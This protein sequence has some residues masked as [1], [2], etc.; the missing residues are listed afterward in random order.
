VDWFKHKTGSLD[1]PDLADAVDKHGDAA[2]LFFFGVLEI[3]GREF[4]RLKDGWLIISLTFLRR[5][6][7]KSSAKVEQM[8]NVY[9]EKNRILSEISGDTVRIK[10]PKFIELASD[11]SGRYA[12]KV[13]A[14]PTEA[15]T[16][17]PT[18]IEVEVR[19]KKSETDKNLKTKEIYKEKY[20]EFV[21]LSHE[22]HQKLLGKFGQAG[23]DGYIIRL[24][25]YI[26]QI[27][28][29]AAKK[30][31]VSHYHTILNWARKDGVNTDKVSPDQEYYEEIDRKA[32][33][34]AAND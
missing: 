34:E 11:W 22:E 27:G 5:K 9:R 10:I 13:S 19:S 33:E 15:P 28:E 7:R 12:R 31:Y 21:F 18:A 14:T 2:Y 16:E 1:D 30:K 4:S 17:A 32:R 6:L 3:Y 20:G 23:A 24:N 29:A 8:L 26:G 25:N